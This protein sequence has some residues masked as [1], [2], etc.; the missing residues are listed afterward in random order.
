MFLSPAK[1]ALPEASQMGFR[2]LFVLMKLG[3]DMREHNSGVLDGP[4]PDELI[5]P[6]Q[7]LAARESPRPQ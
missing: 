6:V 7:A 5:G 2:S 4:L 1:K 3:F